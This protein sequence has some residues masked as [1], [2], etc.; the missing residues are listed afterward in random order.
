MRVRDSRARPYWDDLSADAA[1]GASFDALMGQR[2]EAEA[3][4][5]AAPRPGNLARLALDRRVAPRPLSSGGAAWRSGR[6]DA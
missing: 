5:V 6:P 4:D 3:P 1:L 2:L